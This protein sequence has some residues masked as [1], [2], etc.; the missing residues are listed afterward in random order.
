MVDFSSSPMCQSGS[1]ANSVSASV[2]SRCSSEDGVSSRQESVIDVSY[3]T[4][5]KVVYIKSVVSEPFTG[6]QA[7]RTVTRRSS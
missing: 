1:K 2:C 3:R 5:P 6:N 4:A 7:H